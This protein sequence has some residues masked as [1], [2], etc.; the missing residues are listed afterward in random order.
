MKVINQVYET[1]DYTIFKQLAGNRPYNMPNI[2]RLKDSFAKKQIENPII[3]NENFEVIDGQHRLKTCSELGI[4]VHFIICNGLGLQEVQMLNTNMS[5]WKKEDY[6]N[7]YCNMGLEPYLQFREFMDEYPEFGIAACEALLSQK[8]SGG[9]LSRRDKEH[10]T[11]QSGQIAIKYFENGD[12]HIPDLNLSRKQADMILQI[13]PF[14]NGFNRQT[15][16]RAMIS[17]FRHPNFDFETFIKKLE[18]QP[19]ALGH[20]NNVGQYKELIEDIYN[21]RSRNKVSLKY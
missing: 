16:V 4:P 3:V 8:L 20:C 17:L 13:K 10:T 14:Y 7:S 11:N 18:M 19:T 15:F 2:R 6:L 21:Y 5:N 1:N 12:L 9:N